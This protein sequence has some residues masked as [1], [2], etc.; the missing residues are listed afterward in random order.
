MNPQYDLLIVDDDPTQIVVLGA[1]LRP[2]GQVRFAKRGAD[3][4]RL[5][6]QSIPDLMLLDL[7]LPDLGGAAV[8]AEMRR[9][10]LLADVPVIVLSGSATTLAMPSVGS[11]GVAACLTKPPEAAALAACVQDELAAGLRRLAQRRPRGSGEPAAACNR[12]S[13][14]LLLALACQQAPADGPLALLRLAPAG[15][16]PAAD[17]W[18][19]EALARRVRT[20]ARR[21][22]DCIG[23][24]GAEGL[25]VLL[26]DTDA[27]GAACV[28]RQLL[29]GPGEPLQLSA[30][31]VVLGPAAA[32]QPPLAPSMLMG[33]AE[34]A[35]RAA[36]AAGAGLACQVVWQPGVG[37][38]RPLPVPGLDPGLAGRP[39][40]ARTTLAAQAPDARVAGPAL[41]EEGAPPPTGDTG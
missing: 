1:M 17:G 30:G 29:Q 6:R 23:H 15:A 25:A 35:L 27:R 31:F 37:A 38:S 4:L 20:A 19:L 8:L 10:P 21:P 28:A 7:Q 3:A 24:L 11:L 36:R 40:T 41:R 34:D 5:A 18:A 26:P 33:A 14:D 39:H 2:F 22:G 16:T 32:I 12:R 9:S 13:F